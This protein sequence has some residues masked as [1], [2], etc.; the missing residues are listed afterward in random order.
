VGE[1]ATVGWQ[2][3]S[4]V[5]KRFKSQAPLAGMQFGEAL[6]DAM[7]AWIAKQKGEAE[8]KAS[9]DKQ[10]LVTL[11]AMRK[12]APRDALAA[13]VLSG[14]ERW[15]G[16]RRAGAVTQEGSIRPGPEDPE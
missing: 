4:D 15:A 16:R 2:V 12:A 13:Y 8:S 9:P 3:D 7:R 11:K 6:E 10:T 1:P 5:L 14:I